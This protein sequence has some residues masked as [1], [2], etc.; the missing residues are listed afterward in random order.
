MSTEWIKESNC[1]LEGVQRLRGYLYDGNGNDE[2]IDI[3]E[4][5]NDEVEKIEEDLYMVEEDNKEDFE[6]HYDAMRHD[7]EVLIKDFKKLGKDEILKEL[8]R[9]VL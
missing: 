1:C 7:I 6:G 4:Q 3:Y 9:I 2:L 8:K 5:I